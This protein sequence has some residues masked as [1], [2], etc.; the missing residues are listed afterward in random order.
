MRVAIFGG[1]G[2]VGRYLVAALLDHGHEPS[3]LVRAGSEERVRESVRCRLVSGDVSSGSAIADTLED[4]EA[5]IYCIGIMREF[6]KQGI[7]FKALQYDAV[8]RVADSAKSKG[9]RRFLL[10]SANGAKLPGTPYQ[11]TKYRAEQYLQRNGFD[12]TIFRPS[13]IFGDPRGAMEFATQLYRDMIAQPFPAVGFFNGWL[14]GRDEVTMSPVHVED[15]VSAFLHALEN[16]STIGNTYELGGDDELS[17]S[18]MIRR[19]AFTVG[20]KKWILPVPI[21][22]MW[23]AAAMLDRLPFFPI[24]RDQLTMLSEGNTADPAEL[25]ALI[26]RTPKSFVPENLAYLRDRA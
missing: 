12:V 23:L 20:R 5:V 17:W 7:T 15:V 19:V 1:T 11:E 25:R 22:L 4:C 6:P 14:P 10:M 21:R 26:G 16:P 18:E 13:V 9:I 8:V 2:F 3:L 24:T